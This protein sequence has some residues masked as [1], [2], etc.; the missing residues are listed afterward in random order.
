MIEILLFCLLGIVA[1]F[2]AGFLGIGGGVV[3]I[4]CLLGYFTAIHV[5]PEPMRVAIGTTLSSLVGSALASSLTHYR[6]GGIVPGALYALVPGGILGAFL[7]VFLTLSIPE[8][9]TKLL[10]SAFEILVG[11]HF[12]RTHMIVPQEHKTPS[13]FILAFLAFGI[14]S[15][16][17]ML[18]IGGGVFAVP[19]FTFLGLEMRK[20]IGTSSLLTLIILSSGAFAFFFLGSYK[21]TDTPGLWGDIYYPAIPPIL[22]GA[23]LFA[24]IGAHLAHKTSSSFS[25][26]IFGSFLIVAGFY[27]GYSTLLKVM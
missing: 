22:L 19:L 15:I 3:V 7:G 14:S 20:A 10:F 12:W 24:P 18:G 5:L 1:G 6:K 11:I 13:P 23:L 9:Y 25:K 17:A 26:R 4:P 2:L 21:S 8:F 27:L 16:S